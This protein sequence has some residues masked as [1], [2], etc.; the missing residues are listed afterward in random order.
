MIAD[1]I[2]SVFGDTESAYPVEEIRW[3]AQRL[4]AGLS[5]QLPALVV[6]EDAHWAEPTLVDLI[7]HV[8]AA[9]GGADAPALPRATRVPREPAGLVGRVHRPRG[10]EPG[11]QRRAARCCSPPARTTASRSSPRASGNPLFL[12]QLA[13]FDAER[14]SPDR[15]GVP[16][17]LQSLLSARLDGLG[18]ASARSSN[19]RPWSG[20]SSGP[21]QSPI[22]FRPRGAPRSRVISKRSPARLTEADASPAPFEQASASGM[23]SIQ[24]AAYRSLPKG[25]E[26]SSMRASRAVE[27]VARHELDTEQ[28]IGYRLEQATRYRAELGPVDDG[29]R[30]LGERA[31]DRLEA[32]GRRALD[33]E[34]APAAVN[35]LGRALALLGRSASEPGAVTCGSPR[36]STSPARL[37]RPYSL[38]G[39][40]V[41]EARRSGDRRIEW[42]ATVQRASLGVQGCTSSSGPASESR[43]RHSRSRGLSSAGR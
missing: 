10:S 13:A 19:A 26:P 1:R 17:N 38:L 35:L 41:D 27:A 21:A 43:D 42:L 15:G 11:G 5:Q 16:P 24:E 25:G 29:L 23:S 18:P 28:V 7:E 32:A 3:A 37:E 40:A 30:S 4:L 6:I 33:R 36:H 39:K 22:S 31:G 12:E 20:A 14:R 8:V 9:D 2:A 34:D